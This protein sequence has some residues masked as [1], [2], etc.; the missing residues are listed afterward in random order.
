MMTPNPIL[1]K[2]G[3]ADDDRVVIIHVD[4]V[5]MCHA[6]LQAFADLWDAGTISSGAVMTPCPWFPATAAWARAHPDVDLGVHGTV[7]AEW[8]TYRWG[9]VSTRDRTTGLMDA[10]GYFHARE[11]GVWAAAD[12]AAVQAE[13]DA[14][15]E[16]ALAAGI[17]VTHI[18][19]H[20]G[21]ITHP[22][23]ISGYLQTLMRYRR[24]GL[25]PRLSAKQFLLE[26][27][28][29]DEATA[30]QFAAAVRALEES[31]F[32]LLDAVDYLPLDD[33][34]DHIGLTKHKLS[35]LPPGLT[36]FLMHP[37]VDTPELRAMAPDWPSRVANYEAFI[38][39]EIRDF[40]R[41]SG[42]HVIGYRPLR[43]LMSQHLA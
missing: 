37:A 28:V 33:P 2:L 10:D 43:D 22:R 3:F 36:H 31:G 8:D 27:I 11:T 9:P 4:D 24:P 38:S 32:P 42:I 13:V 1:K 26:G 29:E 39:R 7:N 12:A 17:D 30:E 6:S 41:T 21:T 35:A 5:G 19:T 34:T 20:M 16:M 18:D 14:Q 25:I 40:L 15:V 23:F